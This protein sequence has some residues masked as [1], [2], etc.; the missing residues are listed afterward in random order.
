M[1]DTGPAA[2]PTRHR[3]T[4]PLRFG[5]GGRFLLQPAEQRLL[6]DGEPA[7]LGRR[8]LDLLVVLTRQPD[9]LYTKHELLDRVWPGLVVE[10]ANLQ[11]QIANLRKVLGGDAIA[12]VPGRGYRFVA[13]I[14]EPAVQGDTPAPT[15]P[16]VPSAAPVSR[17]TGLFGREA[18]LERLA[19]LLQPGS[20]VTLVGPAG[21]GKT[22][23]ARA[24]ADRAGSCVWVDLAALPPGAVVSGAVARAVGASQSV[25]DVMPQ[26]LQA[27]GGRP[28]LLV[29]DNAEHV[30]D[31]CAAVATG[32]RALPELSLLVTSQLPLA[33]AGERV[34][35]L[36]PLA[37][38]APDDDSAE[39]GDGALALLMERIAA[40]D[41]RYSPTAAQRPLLRS[42]CIQLDGLPLALEMAA[43]RVPVLGVQGVHD[44]LAER[45]ALLT[46]G[47]RGAAERHR[48]LHHALDWSYRLLGA[49]E[50]RLFRALG[51]F[52]GGF[53]LDLVVDLAGPGS[54]P[55]WEVV[56]ELSALADRSLVAVGPEDPPRYRLLETMRAYALERLRESSPGD[57]AALRRRHAEALAALL[58][59]YRAEDAAIRAACEAEMENVREAI[60]WARSGDLALAA[61]LSAAVMPVAHFTGWR[62]ECEQW[63]RSLEAPMR[64]ATGVALPAPV[65]AAW[66][67]EMARA[68]S[69]RADPRAVADAGHA[70]ALWDSAGD[71]HGAL[72]AA[73]I[74]VRSHYRPG[75]ELDRACD[76]LRTRAS[77]MPDLT[78][79][80]QLQ[81]HGA[82]VTA[83][84]A[85][86]D[87]EEILSGRLVEMALAA[88]LGL[89]ARV[90]T[91]ESNVV[92]ALIAMN[93]HAEA[94]ARGRALL[95]RIDS[96]TGSVKG[97]LPW[98][99]QGLL[100]ALV[101]M[102]ALDEAQKLVPR[103]WDTC[104][105]FGVPVTAPTMAQL[106][107]RRGRHEEAALLI[108]YACATFEAHGMAMD[109]EG[110]IV[111]GE[112]QARVGEALGVERLQALTGQGRLLDDA[113]AAL[114]AQAG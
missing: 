54:R 16:P 37:L 101:M 75:P 112:V 48:T 63:L 113:N 32:L 89:Q 35:R 82:L 95:A 109:N 81:I 33:V 97:N 107:A 83:A 43:A 56:D 53:T 70:I 39:L 7:A 114:L 61:R 111:I 79:P 74:D 64:D 102:G 42:I 92:F 93:R 31:A 86:E 58:A 68:G 4:A 40:A 60:A 55:R 8:A 106:A 88:R 15:A 3:S 24:V 45:F 105:H 44:A 13:P 21:V 23:L 36:E 103:A 25:G 2:D 69:M 98:V 34:Q 38:P 14:V 67:T 46:R 66:W 96:D 10:E 80:E 51:V 28:V 73:C 50:Q 62:S 72:L 9:H 17:T 29:L 5:P 76:R 91:A 84:H 41:H 77:A 19:G 27:L 22:S 87:L 26:V 110:L 11:M 12:T 108:G 85:R 6:V 49:G 30:I 94:A 47:H 65:Q 100:K 52:A 20:C 18:D 57:E 90:D 59:R 99:L 78:L 1:T 71:P 104:R